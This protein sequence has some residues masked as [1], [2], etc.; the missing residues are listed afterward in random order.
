MLSNTSQVW[1]RPKGLD[2]FK[3]VSRFGS[4]EDTSWAPTFPNKNKDIWK[5]IFVPSQ[6]SWES[7]THCYPLK[8]ESLSVLFIGHRTFSSIGIS[9]IREYVGWCDNNGHALDYRICSPTKAR[10]FLTARIAASRTRWKEDKEKGHKRSS[11][12]EECAVYSFRVAITHLEA[13]ARWQG[14]IYPL[15]EMEEICVLQESL[16]KAQAAARAA[17]R[18]YAASSRF[19]TKRL[20]VDE[21]AN[22]VMSWWTGEGAEVAAK[23]AGGREWAQVRGLM[24]CC[25]QRV[26][27][28][29]GADLRSIR[30]SMLFTHAL[31][32]TE[33]IKTCRV[34]GASLRHVKECHENVEHLLG[35]ARAKNRWEC[36]LGA[37]AAYLVYINDIAGE[38][39]IETLRECIRTKDTSWHNIMLIQCKGT[40]NDASISYST[41]NHICHAGIRAANVSD[42]SAVTHLDR[43]TVGC[44]LIE[45]GVSI[46]DT[47]M[48]QGWYHNVAADCYLRGAFKTEPMLIA[49]GWDEGRKGYECWWEESSVPPPHVESVVFPG[50]NSLDDELKDYGTHEG[51]KSI[52]QFIKCLKLLRTIYIADAII[53]QERFPSFP[54]Y[55]RHPLFDRPHAALHTE[56]IE[57]KKMESLRIRLRPLEV[58][59]EK[60]QWIVDAVKE[61]FGNDHM[62]STTASVS[63]ELTPPSEGGIDTKI[64]DIKEPDSLYTSYADWVAR[65]RTY[66]QRTTRPPW[67]KQYGNL[68]RATKVRYCHVRPYFEYLDSIP[69]ERVR[70][71]I[72]KLD[73]IRKKHNVKPNVF[74]KY[75]FYSLKHGVCP[76]KPP[77]IMPNILRC[78][79]RQSELEEVI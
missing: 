34:I 58:A 18:D 70:H 79:M 8:E 1:F 38:N 16:L 67:D 29:R 9:I 36:P 24:L 31:P 35:W 60:Q 77:A 25:L 14:Y 62:P 5:I 40:P 43:T 78:D 74:I 12:I 7:D 42:K 27:G 63:L 53:K 52:I 13:V 10:M 75:C 4:M 59:R 44:E 37:L 41:H 11:L 32:K 19:L 2:L 33:P 64:P 48:Y 65:C 61:A 6:T 50:L 66:F 22:I 45:R 30:L 71:V 39:I 69:P 46:Q 54:A 20:T 23:T 26:L 73:A 17:T 47:G 28:R 3:S 49:H 72:D 21:R 15:L 56:W 76:S 55:D 51:D 57:Y 68:A